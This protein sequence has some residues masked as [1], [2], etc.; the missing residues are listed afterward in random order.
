MKVNE[1]LE[2]TVMIVEN[3]N[4]S[5]YRI[6][7]NNGYGYM[8]VYDILPGIQII[9]NDFHCDISPEGS[10]QC[11]N[12]LEINHCL[13]GRFECY[14][15]ENRYCYLGEGDVSINDWSIDRKV[16]R[17]PLG[18]YYGIEILVNINIACENELLKQF[19]IDLCS[20]FKKVRQ[21][22]K[23]LIVRS[24]QRIEHIF[25]ELYHDF[26]EL[27]KDYLKIK[28]LELLYFLQDAA[29]ETENER[30]YYTKKQIEII[31]NI[32]QELTENLT[33]CQVQRLC[34]KYAINL[35]KLR[36]RFKDIYGKPIYKWHK[37]YRLQK[38]KNLLE[39]TDMSII[40]VAAYIGYD[41]PSK[42]AAA[43]YKYTNEKPLNY[44]KNHKYK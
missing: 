10:E 20:L 23:V 7:C 5:K 41:N 12:F 37:E 14:F 4:Y 29:F 6:K 19:H 2:D 39:K 9:L 18:Y 34:D 30:Q 11:D 25:W 26:D 31:E 33:E 1:Y 27:K 17:F 21:N 22:H 15:E 24:T 35:S 32:K 42:F 3:D 40:E 43:F 38:A 8:T 28:V 44:R 16:S 13:Q 36:K